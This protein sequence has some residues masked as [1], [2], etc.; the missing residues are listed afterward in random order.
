MELRK[1][2]QSVGICTIFCW[3]DKESE[4]FWHK[5][6]IGGCSLSGL[7]HDYVIVSACCSA[8]IIFLVM[9]IKT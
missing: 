4:G 2:L 6:V 8:Y 7:E 5:Q 3:G 1:R 9:V